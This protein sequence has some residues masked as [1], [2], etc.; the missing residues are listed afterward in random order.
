MPNITTHVIKV[1]RIYFDLINNFQ[2]ETK[3]AFIEQ[4]THDSFVIQ[5]PR[6]KI[7]VRNE[8]ETILKVFNQAYVSDDNKILRFDEH[9]I[10]N[11]LLALM[12]KRLR[13]AATEEEVLRK[14]EIEEEV[15][16]TIEQHIRDKQDLAEQLSE[17]DKKIIEQEKLIG[18][19][20]LIALGMKALFE[21]IFCFKKQSVRL[22]TVV[23]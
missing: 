4:L 19:Q 20:M 1:N 22:K 8:L 14:I 9:D 15:E 11:E 12:A 3:E 6:L 13:K 23:F 16:N 5:I 21:L 18:K 2:I 17:K 7:Q 10:N